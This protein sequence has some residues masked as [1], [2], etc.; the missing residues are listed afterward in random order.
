MSRW[1]CLFL[2]FVSAVFA[3]PVSYT[4]ALAA[5]PAN[6]QRALLVGSGLDGPS[7]FEVAP[8]GRIFILERTGKVKIFKNG[9]LLPQPFIDLPSIAS[10]DRGLIG[11]A[12]DPDFNTNNYVYFYYTALD[13]LNYLVRLDASGDVAVEAPHILYQT[14]SPSELLHVGG[15]IDFGPDGKLY[16][17]VGDNGYPPNAQVLDNPHGKIMRINKDGSIPTDNP[18]VGS[19]GALP[20]IWAYGFR[21]PWRFQF[22]DV[23]GFLFGGDVGDYTWEEVNKIELGKNYGWPRAEGFC[24]GCPFE[25]PIYAYNHDGFSS[26]VTGG[27]VYRGTMFPEEYRGN[28]FFADYARGFIRRIA[29]NGEG[30][31]AGV[32]DFDNA[33]GTVVDLKQAADGS[34]YYITYYPGHLYRISYSEGNNIPV[35]FA[36]SDKRGGSEPLAVQF[37][38]AGS[39]DPDN[40]EITYLWNFGNGETSTEANPLYTFT[41]RGRY[42][43]NLTVTDVNGNSSQAI[44]LLIQ[45]GIPPTVLVS[46]PAEGYLY[47]AGDDITVNAHAIDAFGNDISDSQIRTDIIFHHDTHTH[48]FIDG[49]V[50]RAHTFTIPD[51]GEAA[52]NTWYR[53]R[54]T[55]TD[56]GGLSSSREINIYPRTSEISLKTMP[57]GLSVYL[58]GKPEPDGHSF[59]GVEQFIRELSAEPEQVADG[60]AYVFQG[61]SNGGSLRHTILTPEADTTFTARYQE[62]PAYSVAYFNNT[63]LTGTPVYTATD[64]LINENWSD[65]GP[66]NGVGTD[67]FSARWTRTHDFVAGTYTFYLATDD[68]VRVKINDTTVI[69][70]W[71]DQGAPAVEIPV[72]I[73]AGR[74]TV[75]VEYYESFGGASARVA[76]ALTTPDGVLPSPTPSLTPSP[77]PTLD[78]HVGYVGE[79]FNNQTLS[80]APV[81]KRLYDGVNFSWGAGSPDSAVSDDIF[82][83]RF[84]RHYHDLPRG[85]YEF[86]VRADDGVRLF[87][88]DELLID[89]WIL[90]PLTEYTVTK[91]LT[92]T[93]NDFVIEYFEDYGD[94]ALGFSYRKIGETVIPGVYSTSYWNM[95]VDAALPYTIPTDAPDFQTSDTVIDYS[96]GEGSPNAAVQTDRFIGQWVT[97]PT[98]EAGSYRFSVTADDGVRVFVDDRLVIDQWILQPA[99]T[100]TA[101]L[102]MTA[103]I[104]RVRVEYYEYYGDAVIQFGYRKV[105]TPTISPSPVPSATATPV[106]TPTPS[107]PPTGSGWNAEYWDMPA[108][109]PI[110]YIFPSRSPELVRQ[111]AAIDFNWGAGSPNT[112]IS[113]DTFMARW[114]RTV[115]LAE[116]TYAFSATADDGVRVFVNDSLVVDRWVLQPATTTTASISLPTGRHTIRVEYFEHYGDAVAEVSYARTS[117]V[118][119]PPVPTG[120]QGEYW[121]IPTTV[122]LPY[123][124]PT[125]TPTMTRQDAAI[126]FDWT[127]GLPDSRITVDKFLARW[128]REV[129]LEA[130]TYNFTTVSDD[131]VRV[132]VND[133][134]VIDQWRLMGNE[135]NSGTISLPAGTHRLRVEYFEHFGGA[136]VEMTYVRE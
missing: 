134:P 2:A 129:T 55:A 121:N 105:A 89:Q 87:V 124:I 18:F 99:T 65:G 132:F 73:A 75:T 59:T 113:A 61:W 126:D 43:V 133:Q 107:Q 15:S 122:D 110:P 49:L 23:T 106:P 60:K 51:R 117:T 26:A 135:T 50:G 57:A 125:S 98:F 102:V 62:V 33:A 74:Q 88:N 103:G 17:A 70:R 9:Q 16:F 90:Q 7:G 38:S 68:G 85:I 28:L 1:A 95:S 12:F 120:W 119:P 8:D 71:F 30:R 13:K 131:G 109:A 101:D 24:S 93:H 80:G 56:P 5:P 108:D 27:P 31:A 86:K 58:D 34:L 22:D 72:Y 14:F 91:E 42:E 79:F 123:T 48:P 77:S 115:D 45:V 66:G 112:A 63:D 81:A 3:L 29:L 10:G 130:G 46:L 96:W 92:D 118:T 32:F 67:Q 40:D 83:A 94:A 6:F 54:V 100:Y 111:D 41:T 69:D 53:I 47:Q 52:A 104:H 64:D 128:T 20:E 21:N 97:D 25:N 19:S 76:Y 11:I 35:V 39:F 127:S 136:S 114:V 78:P 82:S 37:S 84:S 4:G 44:P 116:G 36:G